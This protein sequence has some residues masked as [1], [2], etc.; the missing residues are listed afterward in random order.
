MRWIII[1]L[2]LTSGVANAVSEA[3]KLDALQ[4]ATGYRL[5]AEYSKAVEVLV[6]ATG[7]MPKTYL[8]NLQLGWLHYMQGQYKESQGYYQLAVQLAPSAIE[9]RLGL[10][11]P[12]LALK[13]W[14]TAEKT[15]YQILNKEPNNYI[16]TLR[17]LYAL[18]QQ[19]K[20]NL[21]LR[22]VEKQISLYPGNV[23]LL[24]EYTLILDALGDK[25][26]AEMQSQKAQALSIGSS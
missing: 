19:G 21:A 5:N 14:K 12:Q 2:C 6:S 26:N 11:L 1:L 10:L 13:S 20:F 22:H 17:L 25:H 7:T 15:A 23:A 24:Q 18:R 3:K 9:P 8:F 16:A 4:K